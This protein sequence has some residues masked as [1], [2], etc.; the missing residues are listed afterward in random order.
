[1]R[2]G[3]CCRTRGRPAVRRVR[4]GGGTPSPAC[5]RILL[6]GGRRWGGR[7]VPACPW[8]WRP[9]RRFGTPLGSLSYYLG[10]WNI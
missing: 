1:M 6:R 9:P 4:R 7:P 2:G 8:A 5:R 3:P 10:R